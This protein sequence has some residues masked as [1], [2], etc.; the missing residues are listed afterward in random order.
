MKLDQIFIVPITIITDNHSS[1]RRETSDRAAG[2]CACEVAQW[3]LKRHL[4]RASGV[5]PLLDADRPSYVQE[6]QSNRY[7]NDYNVPQ[8]ER[9]LLAV[10]PKIIRHNDFAISFLIINA[11]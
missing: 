1:Q 9:S 6:S 3:I 2:G 11:V 4:S 7:M 10:T 5:D 8:D